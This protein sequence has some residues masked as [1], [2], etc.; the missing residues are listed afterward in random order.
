[1]ACGLIEVCQAEITKVTRDK[2]RDQVGGES[3]E[4]FTGARVGTDFTLH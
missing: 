3:Q 2:R 1:M 4:R